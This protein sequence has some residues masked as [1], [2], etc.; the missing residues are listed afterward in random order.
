MDNLCHTLVGAALAE[1]G[2]RRK[3]PLATATLLVAANLPDVD[4]LLYWV[5]RADTAYGF[6]RGWTHGLPAVAVWPF[7]LTGL[8]LLWDRLVRRRR[9]P[10]AEPARPRA[11]LWLSLTALLTHPFLDFVN[12]Y[13]MRWLMPFRDVWSYGDTLFIADP[14]IWLALGTGSYI[15]S[16]RRRRGGPHAGRPAAWALALVAVYVAAMGASGRAA[17]GVAR[18]EIEHSG[19]TVARLMVGPLPATPFRRQV[20][21]DVGDRYVLGTLDWLR[22]PRFVPNPASPV[23]KRAGRPEIA[24]AARTRAGAAFLHWARFPFFVVER[25]SGAT[26]VRIV[27]AR[28]TLDPAASF[29]ALSVTLPAAIPS[30]RGAANQEQHPWPTN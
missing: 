8:V 12:T 9:D 28:Y 10:A 25:S 24:E 14:W 21:A 15:A 5:N 16:R 18:A 2:L 17:R 30:P 29:G 26:V 22:R 11:L 23:L 3:T 6:R 27:D 7:V 4:G 19:A 1:A 20:V 13:G